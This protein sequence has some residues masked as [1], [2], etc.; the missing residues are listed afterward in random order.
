MPL[1]IPVCQDNPLDIAFIVDAS[2]SV[3]NDQFRLVVDYIKSVLS[4]TDIDGGKVHAAVLT[5]STDVAVHINLN[6]FKTRK[7]FYGALDGIPYIPGWTNAAEALRTVRTQVFTPKTGD[8]V[9]VNNV[10]LLITDGQ[11]NINKNRTIL[12]ARN[13]KMAGIHVLAVGVGLASLG[14]V[15]SIVTSPANENRF[16][17][18]GYNNLRG[19]GEVLFP[20]LCQGR[21][22]VC[23]NIYS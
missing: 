20:F 17:V 14:E 12:E 5:Y 3:G 7:E 6:D 9:E 19:L 10:A 21:S 15:D 1:F 16:T 11:S 4:T 2:S 18:A 23:D 8:R 22:I 13:L